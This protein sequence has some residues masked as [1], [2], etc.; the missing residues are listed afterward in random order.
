MSS[1]TRPIPTQSSNVS[2]VP[3]QLSVYPIPCVSS[4]PFPTLSPSSPQPR[5]SL[6]PPIIRLIHIPRLR[7]PLLL[8]IVLIRTPSVPT[9]RRSRRRRISTFSIPRR[10]V[11]L[12]YWCRALIV[13]LHGLSSRMSATTTPSTDAK[14]K[15][16]EDNRD[17]DQDT[18]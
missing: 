3:S 14:Q 17:E 7:N 8:S 9:R 4:P 15:S 18:G 12:I 16:E 13:G 1:L 6:K 2:S 5:T 10:I 11:I